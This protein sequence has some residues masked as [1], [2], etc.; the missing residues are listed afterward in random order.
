MERVFEVIACSLEDAIA[1]QDGGAD[2]IE[3][4]SR[5]DLQGITPDVDMVA[6]ILDA[7]DIPV[8][9][10][11]RSG[12]G[13]SLQ[14]EESDVQGFADLPID[15]IIFGLLDSKNRLDFPAMDTVL[16]RTQ[17]GWGW[18]LH[19][20]FDYAAGSV[21]EKL[22][23]VVAHGRADHILTGDHWRL[24]PPY[25]MQFIAGGGLSAANIGEYLASPC[26]EFHFGRAVRS[27]E[28][29]TAP[30]D[31]EKVRSLAMRLNRM[32]LA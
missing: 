7:V 32:T 2:R 15:G 16:R 4:C 22:A 6:A 19:R 3:V 10:M 28:E 12:E 14:S 26:R 8:R 25:G 9:V 5:L 11:I 1:A 13:F 23:A 27:P 29:T 20:A 17:R 30:V 31:V 24:P 21:E 18:T